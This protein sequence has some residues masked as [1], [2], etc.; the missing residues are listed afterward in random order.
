VPDVDHLVLCLHG[1]VPFIRTAGLV[2]PIH[3]EPYRHI[4]IRT[5]GLDHV[6]KQRRS[7]SGTLY[8]L[9]VRYSPIYLPLFRI[10]SLP[11]SFRRTRYA[12]IPSYCT[13]KELQRII[14]LPLTAKWYHAVGVTYNLWSLVLRVVAW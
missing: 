6:G 3:N 9:A 10:A 13:A 2:V 1:S 7:C 11:G 8:H 12:M 14:G 4:T 5:R